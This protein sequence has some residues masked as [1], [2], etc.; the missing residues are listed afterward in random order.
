MLGWCACSARDSAID[1][2]AS[3]SSNAAAGTFSNGN[4]GSDAGKSAAGSSGVASVGGTF[5]QGGFSANGGGSTG[6]NIA[7]SANVNAGSANASGGSAGIGGNTS[8]SLAGSAG[9][10]VSNAGSSGSSNVA[11]AAGSSAAFTQVSTILGK[12]CGIK[13]C[14]GDKQAPHFVPGPMLYET[15]TGA[16]TVIAECDY[17]KLVEAGDPSKSALVRLMNKK[18]GTFIMP[19]SCNQTTCLSAADLKTLSDWI[20]AG[21]PP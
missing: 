3:G 11:G 12:N 1:G 19:P 4:S 16:N 5:A 7:G 13:G 10:P 6:T 15:L 2:Q 21:A 17:T 20:Q 18:C 14:H 8:V 9:T